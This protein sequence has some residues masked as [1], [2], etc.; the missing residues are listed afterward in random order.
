MLDSFVYAHLESLVSYCNIAYLL[1]MYP[2]NS[3]PHNP[4]F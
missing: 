2:F 3:L 1:L 4:D